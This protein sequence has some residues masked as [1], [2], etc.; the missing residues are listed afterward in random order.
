MLYLAVGK[1]C[2][3]LAMT[4]KNSETDCGTKL[5]E[6]LLQQHASKQKS[7]KSKLVINLVLLDL[8]GVDTLDQ[9]AREA[10]S[11]GGRKRGMLCDAAG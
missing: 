8:D 6:A 4:V 1:S 2:S 9:Y 5:W 3:T 10:E 7:V 11:K